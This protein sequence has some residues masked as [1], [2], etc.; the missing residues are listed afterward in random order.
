MAELVY[1]PVVTPDSWVDYQLLATGDGLKCE[2][3]GQYTLVRPDPQ[4]LWPRQAQACWGEADA[5][6]HRNKS[7]GGRWEVRRK[8]PEH[9]QIGWQGLRF[10]IRPT[11][12]KHT[13]LFPEQAANW[14]WFSRIIREA[15]QPVSVLNLFG[16]T[17]GAT[18]AAAAAGASVC[19]V[20][21]AKSMVQWCRDNAA[22][23]GLQEA[24]IRYITDDCLKFVQ[25][26]ARRGRRYDAIIMDP[27]VYG[28]GSG[29]EM[30][31]LEDNLVPLLETCQRI[32]SPRPLFFLLNSYTAGLSPVAIGNLLAPMLPE[33]G[34]LAMGEIALRGAEDQR[35]LPCGVFGRWSGNAPDDDKQSL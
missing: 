31:K 7:G 35:L 28:R 2:R 21:A 9:W 33:Q 26:E 3:W 11:Q 1:S 34:T 19:H 32:L 29:G 25:R 30:W 13:G 22:L 20:D 17:G 12:F 27:P 23:S 10:R 15:R 8:L 6:Y 14:E 24:P 16:Y 18:L 4:A 5:T